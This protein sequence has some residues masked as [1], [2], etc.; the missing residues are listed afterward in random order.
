MRV[1]RQRQDDGSLL[2]ALIDD[3][4]QSVAVVSGFLRHLA[5]RGCSPN[6]LTAYGYG[7]GAS[8]KGIGCPRLQRR[9]CPSSGQIH[10]VRPA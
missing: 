2:V 1:Y 8:M 4:G 5:A 9:A 3:A 10:T 6:T 7:D